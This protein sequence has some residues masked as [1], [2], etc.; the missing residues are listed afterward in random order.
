MGVP[1]MTRTSIPARSGESHSSPV[2]RGSAG[3]M[4]H[5]QP[6]DSEPLLADMMAD[7]VVRRVMARDGVAVEQL[8]SLL[9][10]M[11]A[12]LGGRETIEGASYSP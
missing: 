6:G 10:D 1:I 12:R 5:G 11:R 7:D 8:L 2:P 4:A 9:D 3:R